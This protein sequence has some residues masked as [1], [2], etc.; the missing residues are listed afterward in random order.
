M[1]TS[2]DFP[3]HML[4]ISWPVILTQLC[5]SPYRITTLQEKMSGHDKGMPEMI[6]YRPSGWALTKGYVSYHQSSLNFDDPFLALC[7][8][9]L[10]NLKVNSIVTA[11]HTCGLF[12][13]SIENVICELVKWP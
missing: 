9:Q 8:I 4:S 11:L 12:M 7:T 2:P 10:L 3:V 5:V 13:Y 6:I 1:L